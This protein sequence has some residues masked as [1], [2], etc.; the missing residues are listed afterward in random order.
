M[1]AALVVLWGVLVFGS[2]CRPGPT[3]GPD[4]GTPGVSGKKSGEMDHK[5]SPETKPAVEKPTRIPGADAPEGEIRNTADAHAR[6]VLADPATRGGEWEQVKASGHARYTEA[7]RK[8]LLSLAPIHLDLAAPESEQLRVV[9]LVFALVT[10]KE[11]PFVGDEILEHMR[12]QE[13]I[14]LAGI[15]AISR[16]QAPDATSFLRLFVQWDVPDR[17]REAVIEA[18]GRLTTDSAA[19]DELVKL[20]RPLWEEGKTSPDDRVVIRARLA[21]AQLD[22]LRSCDPSKEDFRFFSAVLKARPFD[23]QKPEHRAVARML[24]CT[25]PEPGLRMLLDHAGLSP[26]REHAESLGA[27]LDSAPPGA[28]R[29]VMRQELSPRNRPARMALAIL[30]LGRF[31]DDTDMTLL[32]KLT[33]RTHR[34]PGWKETL[35]QL[36]TESLQSL[37]RK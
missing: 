1:K 2:A 37:R 28:V 4:I 26:T 17:L 27:L 33:A 30:A 12:R 35:G 22:R 29:T 18:L 20:A 7:F 11:A 6:W 8:A 9:E 24:L 34:I 23:A 15:L 13:R 16:L 3:R 19:T 31:G 21:V 25:D 10:P 32:E 5:E 14:S 36:A